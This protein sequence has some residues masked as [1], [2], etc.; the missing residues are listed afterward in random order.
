MNVNIQPVRISQNKR[1][2]CDEDGAPF[3]WLGDTAWELVQ[4]LTDE[5]I[6]ERLSRWKPVERDIP[7][8]YMRRYVKYVGSAAK[9][10]VLD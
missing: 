10:A 1:F 6:S 2:L 3:F 8:G 5:E 4:K 9:G 7:E